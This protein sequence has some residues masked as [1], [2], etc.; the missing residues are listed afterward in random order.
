MENGNNV[1]LRSGKKIIVKIPQGATAAGGLTSYRAYQ[2]A[3]TS[4]TLVNWSL[5]ASGTIAT[6]LDTVVYTLDSLGMRQPAKFLSS[7]SYKNFNLAITGFPDNS[8]AADI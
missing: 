5:P 3:D 4:R 7:I 1:Y 2:P 6:N 8:P